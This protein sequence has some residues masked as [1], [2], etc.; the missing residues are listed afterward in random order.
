MRL[1]QVTWYNAFTLSHSNVHE[2]TYNQH[3][4]H[5]VTMRWPPTKWLSTMHSSTS[6]YDRHQ[7]TCKHN[8]S[9]SSDV[10]IYSQFEVNKVTSLVYIVT[11]TVVWSD[12]V[13]P[14]Y[15]I[16]SHFIFSSPCM[17]SL[18]TDNKSLHTHYKSLHTETKSLYNQYRRT[19]HLTPQ[20][21]RHRRHLRRGC[22][23]HCHSTRPGGCMETWWTF[24]PK[25]TQARPW[26][27]YIKS[28]HCTRSH[29]IR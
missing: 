7:V 24:A 5:R 11:P 19:P 13:K 14:L 17:E 8:P 21:R 2:V 22:D 6:H 28:I 26:C 25:A 15:V 12:Y 4:P 1:H 23:W 10:S 16:W 9:D 18:H 20:M 29:F 3:S 27:V